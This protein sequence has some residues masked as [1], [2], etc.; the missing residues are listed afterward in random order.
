MWGTKIKDLPFK[1]VVQSEIE[2]WRAADFWTKEP[3]T[4]AWI[5]SLCAGER[6]LGHRGEYW[7]V[8]AVCGL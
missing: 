4:I 5:D 2:I 8:F 1:L 6:V 3:E 7:G